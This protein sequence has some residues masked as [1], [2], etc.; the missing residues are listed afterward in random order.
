ML[1]ETVNSYVQF[2]TLLM[3]QT[4]NLAKIKELGARITRQGEKTKDYY[5]KL[6]SL[7]ANNL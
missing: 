6:C 4:P 7:N 1:E 2:W 5:D 3:D